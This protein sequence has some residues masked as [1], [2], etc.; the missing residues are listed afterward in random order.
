MIKIVLFGILAVV[1]N[2][3]LV[4]SLFL[5]NQKSTILVI[6]GAI[7]IPLLVVA[8]SIIFPKILKLKQKQ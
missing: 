2:Y 6:G 4:A 7:I 8:V 1:V 5:M 3:G